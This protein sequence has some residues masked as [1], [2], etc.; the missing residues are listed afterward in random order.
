[1]ADLQIAWETLESIPQPEK[2]AAVVTGEGT[3]ASADEPATTPSETSLTA[4][5]PYLVYISDPQSGDTKMVD[6]IEKVI[7]DDDR[8]QLGSKAFHMVKMTAESAAAD[9][10]LKEKGGKELPRLVFITADLKSV[11]P[12]EGTAL[13]VSEVWST[14]KLVANKAYKQDLEAI[15]KESLKILIEYDKIAKERTVLEEKEKRTADKASA[16]D[17]KDIEAKRAELD[18]RQEKAQAQ[19]AKLFELKPKAD[20]SKALAKAD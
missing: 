6:N 10:L 9:A 11:K 15:V 18:A 20:K 7:L 12:V 13:K 3:T 1:M 2:A 5:K 17:K 8:I 19:R 4:D 14:M 16:S